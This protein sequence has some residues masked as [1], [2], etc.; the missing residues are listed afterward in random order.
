MKDPVDI[1]LTLTDIEVAYLL[2]TL[3]RRLET[4]KYNYRGQPTAPTERI[5]ALIDKLRQE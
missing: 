5:E 1:T 2:D 4:I 3:E